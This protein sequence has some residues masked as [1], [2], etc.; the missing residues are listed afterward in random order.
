MTISSCQ[1]IYLYSTSIR[2]AYS[3]CVFYCSELELD[4]NSLDILTTTL[5]TALESVDLTTILSTNIENNQEN[6]NDL[7]TR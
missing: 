3:V 2:V 6:E 7:E 1:N 4:D 5:T